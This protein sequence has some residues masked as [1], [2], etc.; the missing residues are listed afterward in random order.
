MSTQPIALSSDLAPRQVMRAEIE[1]HDLAVWRSESGVVSAWENRCPHR[2]M[3]L[4]HGFVRGES[5]ACAYHGWHFECSGRCHYMPAHPELA[6]PRTIAPITYDAVESGG[7]VWVNVDGPAKAI[8]LGDELQP[9]RSLAC[10]CSASDLVTAWIEVGNTDTGTA[11]EAALTD[12]QAESASPTVLSARCFNQ[13]QRARLLLQA[14]SDDKTIVHVLVPVSLDTQHCVQVSRRCE[15][16]RR[17]VE[18]V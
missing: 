8:D 15:S 13:T 18:A 7:L 16:L 11:P 14:P 9:L 4:S 17:Q 10:A 1:Q 12:L 5:L 6:L 3:R 2:G